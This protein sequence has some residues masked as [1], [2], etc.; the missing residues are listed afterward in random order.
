MKIW[1]QR[2]NSKQIVK[3]EK[4]YGPFSLMIKNIPQFYQISD[5]R[6]EIELIVPD[7]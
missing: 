7:V 3:E 4:I 1:L 2:V 6:K 5:V